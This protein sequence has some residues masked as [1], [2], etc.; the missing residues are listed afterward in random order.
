MIKQQQK[1]QNETLFRETETKKEWLKRKIK[2]EIPRRE[3][4]HKASGFVHTI[5]LMHGLKTH[6]YCFKC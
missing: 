2:N 4:A 3:I 1:H 5:T 6:L